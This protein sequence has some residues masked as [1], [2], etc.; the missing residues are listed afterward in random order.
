MRKYV[1]YELDNG[2]AIVTVNNPPV[3][4]LT[5]DMSNELRQVFEELK[6]IED[7]DAGSGV[8]R[9]KVVIL[10]AVNH[11][12]VFIAGADINLFLSIKDRADGVRLGSFY[13]SIINPISESGSPVICA[14][15]GLALGGG[16]E[17]ALACDIRIASSNAEFG[18]TEVRLGV[19]PGGGGTQRLARLIGPG[20]AKQMIFTG[21]RINAEEALRIGLIEKLV[22]EGEALNEA[23][24]MAQAMLDNA[25]TA[26]KCAKMAIDEGLDATMKEGLL[27]EQK[28]LGMACDSG[29]P[30]EGARAFLEKRKPKFP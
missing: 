11:K 12:G 17:I 14:V 22:P 4:S 30:A 5:E 19:L 6:A 21:K 28:A 27:I 26:I 25:P 10:T 24:I 18:L 29:E 8:S 20:K 13:Q 7:E 2:L 16:T 9:V 1:N 23:K 3:N 15:N